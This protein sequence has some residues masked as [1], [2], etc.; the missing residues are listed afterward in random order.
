VLKANIYVTLKNGV[1]DPQGEAVKK[2]LKVLDYGQVSDVRIGK[3]IEVWLE[4]ADCDSALKELEE[5]TDKLLANPVIEDY[6]V[7]IVEV[8]QP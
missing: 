4:G 6:R 2:S 7:E 8:N 5:M 1:L 3:F